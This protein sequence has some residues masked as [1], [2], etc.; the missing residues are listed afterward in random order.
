M[1]VANTT[2]VSAGEQQET[3]L[4]WSK[5]GEVAC[6]NH[7]PPYPSDEWIEAGWKRVP[8]S[9]QGFHTSRLQCQ[10]CHGG[11]PYVRATGARAADEERWPR[12]T[13]S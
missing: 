5:H 2:S 8:D 11:R 13:Q 7:A 10:F 1:I 3:R 12:L 6:G 9:R 4:F